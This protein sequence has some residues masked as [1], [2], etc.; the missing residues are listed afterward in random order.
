MA[1]N[2]KIRRSCEDVFRTNSDNVCKCEIIHFSSNTSTYKSLVFL[3]ASSRAF[4]YI[5]SQLHSYLWIS[6][7]T[8][9]CRM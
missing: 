8:V 5:I 9:H 1:K 6:K 4:V 2:G 3:N 7:Y